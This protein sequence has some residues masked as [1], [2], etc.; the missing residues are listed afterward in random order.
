MEHTYAIERSV[1]SLRLLRVAEALVDSQV[2][3]PLEETQD[4]QYLRCMLAEFDV[5][6][7]H[8]NGAACVD[9]HEAHLT[10]SAHHAHG[11]VAFRQHVVLPRP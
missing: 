8:T 5:H 10:Y 9:Y 11:L 4:V 6:A 2:E 1:I 7:L 3:G